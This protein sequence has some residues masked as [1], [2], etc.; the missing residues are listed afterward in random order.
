LTVKSVLFPF[1]VVLGLILAWW[2]ERVGGALAAVCMLLFHVLN[3]L[4]HGRF[5]KGYAFILISAPSVVFL[6]AGFL[7][8]GRTKSMTAEPEP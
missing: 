8:A 4:G 7:R 2:F 5:P 3:Y 1:G 6:C